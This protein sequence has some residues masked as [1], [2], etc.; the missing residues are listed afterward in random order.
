M[1][2]QNQ[3]ENADQEVTIDLGKLF[4]MLWKKRLRIFGGTLL[5]ALIALAITTI[6][7]HPTYRSSFVAFVN[8]RTTASTTDAL[9]SGDTAA[10]QSL[11]YT[12]ASILTSRSVIEDALDR[13]DLGPDWTYDNVKDK[14]TTSIEDQT[15]LIDVFVTMDSPSHAYAM[16]KAIAAV[17]PDYIS[18]IV[19]GSSMKIAVKPEKPDKKYSPSTTKNTVIGALIGFLISVAWLV[20][21]DLTDRR[22]KSEESLSE[23]YPYPIVGTI[24]DIYGAAEMK[25]NYGYGSSSNGSGTARGG[26]R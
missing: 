10:A 3:T 4:S 15:Q 6:F 9:S 2:Q 25:N 8:N 7:I 14:V 26:N 17:A 5:C 12:Y 16:A 19:D 22:I 18:N 24:P 23:R 20:I 11:T 13:A 1:N 21:L